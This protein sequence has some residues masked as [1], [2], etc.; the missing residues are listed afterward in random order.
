MKWELN[1]KSSH[2]E[3]NKSKD[4]GGLWNVASIQ[5]NLHQLRP[6]KK[7]I[8]KFYYY[9]FYLYKYSNSIEIKFVVFKDYRQTNL[10]ILL[11]IF[12]HLKNKLEI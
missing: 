8:V 9:I 1:M 12:L 5:N 2:K 10:N 6:L 7:I 3:K 4:A 11:Y